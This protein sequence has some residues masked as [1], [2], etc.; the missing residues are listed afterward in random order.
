MQGYWFIGYMFSLGS[1]GISESAALQEILARWAA[2]GD[3]GPFECICECKLDVFDLE[4]EQMM[5]CVVRERTDKREP[6]SDITL[7]G[8]LKTV[9]FPMSLAQLKRACNQ[10][11]AA[12]D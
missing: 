4:K 5:W 2:S 12:E 6:N 8:T 3:K 9:M 10:V 11:G 1:I 7:L